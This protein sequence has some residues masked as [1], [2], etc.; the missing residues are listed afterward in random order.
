MFLHVGDRL[1]NEDDISTIFLGHLAKEGFIQIKFRDGRLE[2]IEGM[3]A[4]NLIQ[5]LAPQALEG[6]GAKY[7]RHAW[8][9]HNLLGHPLM[10]ILSLLGLP[11]LGIKIHDLTVPFPTTKE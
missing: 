7:V 2:V 4:F 10:Q 8:M 6:R 5:E 1:I 9:I 3:D 11:R